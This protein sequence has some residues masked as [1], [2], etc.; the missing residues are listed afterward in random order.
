M[1]A[2]GPLVVGVDLGGT[3]MQ[4]G[5]VDGSDRIMGR[6]KRMTDAEQGRDAVIGRISEA[7]DEACAGAGVKPSELA[8]IG[9]GA[10]GAIDAAKE[11]VLEAPNLRWNN[12]RLAERLSAAVGGRPV[13]LENDVN[14]AVYGENR[15][16]AGGGARDL[17]GVWI[18]TGVGGGL[19]LNGRLYEG[20][21]GT[22]GEIGQ[23]IL[24][25]GAPLGGRT[26]EENCSR[27]QIVD[28][29]SRLIR[30]NHS[31]SLAEKLNEQHRISSSDV[32]QAYQQGDAL[33]RRVLEE[34]ADFLAV[35]ISGVVTLLGLQRVILGG[36]LS[37]ELGQ[38][39]ADL[40]RDRARERVFPR[41]LGDALE[42]LATRLQADAGL[43]GAAL[44]ARDKFAS[45]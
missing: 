2:K 24:L 31:S 11:V 5:V 3:H 17:L 12:V 39:F 26:L 15:L 45:G 25:P 40:V 33:T 10:P 23:M 44:L 14:V 9:V 19:I 16:G 41:A 6:A 38:P 21:S 18:G 13:L 7:I 37:E 30:A 43:L 1:A 4:I 36:G 34:V 42:V 20:A 29:L 32:A 28:R 35:T 27:R 8:G 22:A